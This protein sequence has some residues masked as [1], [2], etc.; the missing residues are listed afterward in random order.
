MID[1]GLWFVWAAAQA[2]SGGG[3]PSPQSALQQMILMVAVIGVAFWFV[4]LRPQKREQQKQQ[5]MLDSVKK[6]D[7][8]VTIGGIH[9]WVTEVDK[10]GK[11]LSIRVDTKTTLK[12]NRS[13]VSVIE[14]REGEARETEQ[15]T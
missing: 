11:T 4:I 1:V 8:V 15:K 7:R 13:A 10:G 3:A 14:S 12:I 6:G 2:P 9:G 5:N